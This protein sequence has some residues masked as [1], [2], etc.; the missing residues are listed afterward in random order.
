MEIEASSNTDN[1]A[2]KVNNITLMRAAGTLPEV[3]GSAE[4]SAIQFKKQG[5]GI[6]S[7]VY[8]DGYKNTGG[9]NAYSVLIQD[10]ATETSQLATGKIKMDP[11]F[12][13]ANNDNLLKFGYGFTSANPF[14]YT[15]VAAVTKVSL[16][17]GA[18]ATVNG[19]DLLAPLK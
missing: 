18:W 3:S 5:T 7:N 8:I 17:G 12:T 15:N 4:I 16:V 14:S 19:V 10:L 2:P 6:F 11:L 9:K 13:T 1:I